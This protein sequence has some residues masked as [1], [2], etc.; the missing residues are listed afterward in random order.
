[1]SPEPIVFY[2]HLKAKTLVFFLRVQLNVYIAHTLISAADAKLVNF[3]PDPIGS[4][5]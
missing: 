1:M 5:N 3:F 2:I 4:Q